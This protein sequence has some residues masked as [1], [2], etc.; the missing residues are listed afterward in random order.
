MSFHQPSAGAR[1]ERWRSHLTRTCGAIALLWFAT[2][3]DLKGAL[4]A[5]NDQQPNAKQFND[6]IRPFL[7]KHCQGCHS[8]E[9]PKGD[10]RL[11]QISADFA[12]K[13]NREHWQDVLEQLKVG[14]MPPKEKPRPSEQEVRA[15]TEWISGRMSAADLARRATEGRVVLRRL[16]RFEYE[17][18]VRDLLGV[19]TDLKEMLP[20]DTSASGFDNI[21][22]ALHTSS[23]LMERYLEAADAALNMAI[24]NKPQ[25]PS[26]KKRYS[27]KD[28]HPVKSTTESVFRKL[29]GDGLVLFSS[30]AWQAVGLHQFYPNE[31]GYYRF[32]IS[33][34]SIQSDGK[35]VVF[36]VWAGSGGMG[37]AKGHLVGYFDAPADAPEVIEFVERVEP[38]TSISILPYALAGS[39]TVHKIG[40]D[41]YEGPGLQ[42][43][44]VEVEGPL[45][46]I[47]PP[48]SHR[49]IFGDMAQGPAPIYNNST[50]VEVVS[51]DPAA[52]ATRIL[53]DFTR[54]AFRR[55]VT[56]AEVDPFIAVVEAK[57]AEKHTFEQAIRVGLASVMLSP[58]F[59]FLREPPGKLDDFALASRLSYFLWSTMPDEELLNL[60]EEGKLG[61]PATLRLQVDRMLNDPKAKAFTQNF[62]GQWLGLRDIDFTAPSHVL[63]P[64]YDDMLKASMLRETE[65][66]FA[67]VL[68][69]DL[70]LTNFVASDFTMLNGR[71]AKHY[72]IPGVDGWEFRKTQ[73]PPDSHRGGVLTMASVLKVTANGT[74]T[75]PIIR[76]AWVLDRIQGTPPPRPPE[77]VAGLEPDVRGATTIREQ[78][79]KHRQVA[80]CASCHTQID[81]PGFALESFDVIGGWRDNYR[82]TGNGKTVI[83]DGRRMAY[84]EGRKVDPSDVLP[85]GRAFQNIDEFKQ[86]LLADKDQLARSLAEKLLTYS[87]GG[88]PETADRPAIEA[89]VQKIRDKNYGFRSLIQEVVQSESF[90]NK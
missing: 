60:A 30:S 57:L 12:D 41:Q 48:A 72:G 89:I 51:Q 15:L 83:V 86:L 62:V 80:S 65:L 34:S 67:E 90:R 37:G 66:F 14:A 38:R 52:D 82:T 81:P 79:A 8:G 56:D 29:E 55:K 39:Q 25:P 13:E 73:L 11:D 27:L 26:T 7:V 10:L 5:P 44:W 47:W 77:N 19:E 3:Y 1:H 61:Q 68:K 6:Q 71:L 35:P 63:Y 54:R 16:N 17:N 32:R 74:S 70:S 24:A 36:R 78:L 23:F 84:H 58:Q 50:R 18:T 49:R 64:E 21:G 88:A 4:A 69:D 43:D 28:Q 9:K 42:V 31:R 33:C 2:S 76:G 45:N 46:D 75:S 87:T 85:D 20:L 53:R 40:A 59:L 22:D